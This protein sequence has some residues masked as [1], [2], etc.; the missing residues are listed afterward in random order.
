M[1]GGVIQNKGADESGVWLDMVYQKLRLEI[2]PIIGRRDF[3][4]SQGDQQVS[5]GSVHRTC[6]WACCERFPNAG[7]AT[8][9]L[10]LIDD[11]GAYP[12]GLKGLCEAGHFGFHEA[13]SGVTEVPVLL[14]NVSGIAVYK[15]TGP[16]LGSE[17]ES[18]NLFISSDGYEQHRPGF[19]SLEGSS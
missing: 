5:I 3:H 15:R 14:P 1:V 17:P 13:L 2:I 18:L 12:V 7:I 8:P 11:D 6:E 9:K 4:V 10:L 19:C 16:C